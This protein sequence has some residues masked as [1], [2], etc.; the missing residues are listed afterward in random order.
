MVAGHSGQFIP[1]GPAASC[2][3]KTTK[4]T[5]FSQKY[6]VFLFFS[7]FLLQMSTLTCI[8][9]CAAEEQH[10]RSKPGTVEYESEGPL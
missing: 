2:A 3:T 9:I 1:G 8:L 10:D 6:I 7:I 4:K 5:H